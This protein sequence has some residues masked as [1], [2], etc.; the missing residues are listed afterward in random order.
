VAEDSVLLGYEAASSVSKDTSTFQ[1]NYPAKQCHIPED[2]NY[3][4]R[5][6]WWNMPK[7]RLEEHAKTGI[8]EKQEHVI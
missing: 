1:T 3:E 4:V 8:Y 6:Y 2:Q 7:E 5:F